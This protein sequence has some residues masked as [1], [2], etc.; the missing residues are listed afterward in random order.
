MP[1]PTLQDLL[2]A[3]PQSQPQPGGLLGSLYGTPSPRT[4]GQA[5]WKQQA[6]QET[7]AMNASPYVLDPGQ[8]KAPNWSQPGG[9]A[10]AQQA[11][12]QMMYP[13]ML[14]QG[15]VARVV[16]GGKNIGP[17]LAGK[18]P[19]ADFSN[20][21]SIDELAK[22]LAAK[23]GVSLDDAK[24]F[25]QQAMG[26]QGAPTTTPATTPD[27]AP[28]PTTPDPQAVDPNRQFSADYR[29]IG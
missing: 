14:Q 2:A 8:L 21:A 11:N 3:Q 10:A 27:A 25:I 17:D 13:N 26:G 4:P 5:A 9:L 12:Q 22:A 1:A 19:G 23:A 7:Q 24:A 6:S 29:Q 20:I 16:A 28:A 18:A 15:G